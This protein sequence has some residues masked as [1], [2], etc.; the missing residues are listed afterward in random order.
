[1]QKVTK[2]IIP[3]AGLCTR[4]LPAAKSIH[5]CM[6][7]IGEKPIIQYIVEDLVKAGIT[8][9]M[10][11]VGHHSESIVNHFSAPHK[12]LVKSLEQGGEKKRAVL[13]SVLKINNLANFYFA[14]QKSKIGN[15]SPLYD[16]KDFV[17]NEPF[18][19]TW[20]DDMFYGTKQNEYQQLI[21]AY[22]K[23]DANVLSGI[24]LKDP[25]DYSKYAVVSGVTD[26]KN[27]V[28][29]SIY[30]KP[31]YPNTLSLSNIATVSSQLYKPE[32]LKYLEEVY[33]S[34]KENEEFGYFSVITKMITDTKNKFIA[35]P[36]KNCVYLDMGDP[37]A[38]LEAQLL[39]TK[40]STK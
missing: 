12:A 8:D 29:S 16:V 2:A 27:I 20:G 13:E 34:Q 35:V 17:K 14:N 4:F 23:Y 30:E 31:G 10:F 6:F 38:Y 19:Y 26:N 40:Y 1:M 39:I 32:V 33:L 25:E 22:Y 11:V 28:M 37:K 7:P 3:V 5:K 9:I 18:I 15:F 21:S 24:T 36:I